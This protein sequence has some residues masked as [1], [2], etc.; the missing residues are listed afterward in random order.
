[1]FTGIVDHCATIADIKRTEH[2]LHVLIECQ[3]DGIQ[4]GESIS[5][6]GICLTAIDPAHHQFE[7][8]LSPETLAL[9]NAN[10]WQ[11]GSLVNVERSLQLHD[12][13]G[14]HFVMGHV[15]T[16]A[17]LKDITEHGD[18]KGYEF[19]ELPT[20]AG[21]FLVTKGSVAVNGVSLTINSTT[22]DGFSVMLI[23]HTLARSNLGGLQI[24]D[25]VNIE[26]DYLARIIAKQLEIMRTAEC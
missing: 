9:T 13:L 6:D 8:Q 16:T 2:G 21:R 19:S 23:P 14:G 18:F 26:Y 17:V 12:R 1:M 11:L 25:R 20:E 7:A 10:A 5:V 24:E 22:S 15:D 4:P 3:F